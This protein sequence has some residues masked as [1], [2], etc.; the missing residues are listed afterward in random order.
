MKVQIPTNNERFLKDY[1]NAINGILKMTQT[2]I[3]VCA[4]LLGL[5]IDNP[6]SKENRMKAAKQL[7]CSRAVLNNSI[8]SLK[9]KN[10]L[11]Y[12]ANKKIRYTFHPLVYNYKANNVLTFE[13][14]NSGE[15][16]I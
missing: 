14:R 8:K 15:R 1:L 4:T 11:L 10:V 9:D 7:N 13:F 6:C 2:E 3:N 5:D 12:D 16:R